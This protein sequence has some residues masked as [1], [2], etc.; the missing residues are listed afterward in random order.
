LTGR[1]RLHTLRAMAEAYRSGDA[2]FAFDDE[3]RVVCWNEQAE[4]LTGMPAAEALE[5][6][7]WEALAGVGEDG[8]VVCH[9][10]CSGA[11]LA[12][13]GWPLPCRR[14]LIRTAEGRKLVSVSTVTVRRPGAPTV[15]LNVLRN[16]ETVADPPARNGDDA[17]LSPR[18][19]EVLRLLAA[20]LHAK[21]IAAR[22][23]IA[24]V[25]ARNHI[26]AILLELRCHSQLEAVAEAHRRGLV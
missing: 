21:V 2:L 18:Q 10:G 9:R 7:C 25:T 12:R 3:L 14:M 22:L 8:S 16:G 13:Q 4:R 19:L 17:H 20:G 11:R 24:H 23:G 1:R 5:L 26:Q 6:R 15:V